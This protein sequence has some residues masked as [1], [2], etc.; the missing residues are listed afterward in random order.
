MNN[1]EMVLGKIDFKQNF[2]GHFNVVNQFPYIPF[3][4]S[5]YIISNEKFQMFLTKAVNQLWLCMWLCLC[6]SL[7]FDPWDMLNN[8]CFY[9]YAQKWHMSN[10]KSQMLILILGTCWTT[11]VFMSDYAQ[12]SLFLCENGDVVFFTLPP[13]PCDLTNHRA[14]SQL[15]IRDKYHLVLN[16]KNI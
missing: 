12:K 2:I 6:L 5:W 13:A 15:K 10:V 14:G 9:I 16:S 7:S 4:W 1:V 3:L 11:F 8:F